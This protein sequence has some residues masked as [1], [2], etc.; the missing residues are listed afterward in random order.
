MSDPRLFF[1][2]KSPFNCSRSYRGSVLVDK[3]NRAKNYANF[4]SKGKLKKK[5]Q[6]M[7]NI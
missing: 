6:Y 1:I 3:K 5:V 4:K 2:R 7:P